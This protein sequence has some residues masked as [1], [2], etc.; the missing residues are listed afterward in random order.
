MITIQATEQCEK[1]KLYQGC[2]SPYMVSS[3]AENP[4]IMAVGEAPGA[5]EDAQGVPFVGKSG[6]LLREALK[7]ALGG[8]LEGVVRF[9]NVVRCRPPN[10]KITPQAINYCKHFAVEEIEHYKP[11][12]VFLFGNSPLKAILGETGITTWN[13][14]VVEREDAIYVP[15]YHPAYVLRN[16][17]AMDDW[18]TG[19]IN[20]IDAL[21]KEE[22][23]EDQ[24]DCEYP[25]S[26]W[27]LYEMRE[28]LQQ[29]EWIAYDTETTSL[30]PFA[31][32]AKII[33]ISLSDGKK[34]FA[35]PVDHDEDHWT[36]GDRKVLRHVLDMIFADHQGKII[37]HNLKFDLQF[38]LKQ[39]GFDFKSGGDSMLVSHLVDS[40]TGIHSLK[41]LAGL[42]L[43]MYDYDKPLKDYIQ[44]H[45]ETNPNRGGNYGKISLDVLLPYAAL[46][47]Y[48]TY[49]LYWLLY[50]ELTD[51]Q[52][53]FYH[54]VIMPVSDVLAYV[55]FNGFALDPF[56]IDRYTLI[57]QMRQEELYQELA[58]DPKVPALLKILQDRADTKMID[59]MYPYPLA[60][61]LG[62]PRKHFK[63]TKDRILYDDGKKMRNRKRPIVEFNPNSDHQLRI[64]YYKV[65]KIPFDANNLTKT[66]LAQTGENVLRPYKDDF[67]IIEVVRYYKLI[68]KVLSTYLLPARDTWAGVDGKARSDYLIHGS[69][70]GRLASREPNFQNIPS[71]DKEPGTLLDYLPIKNIFTSSFPDGVIMSVDEKGMELRVFASLADCPVMLEI[72]RSGKDFHTMIA[73]RISGVPYEDVT[74]PSRR[75][76]KSVN[77]AM[78]YAGNEYTLY[79]KFGIPIDD[80]RYAISTYKEELPSVE[81]YLEECV[82]FATE[83]GYI[84]TVFGRR[85]ALPYIK[86]MSDHNYQKRRGNMRNAINTPVQSAASDVLL[87]ALIILDAEMYKRKLRAMIVN[88]VHDSIVLDVPRNEIK[89]VAKLC[90]DVMENVV[91]YA[92][93]YMPSVDFSWLK[94]PLKVDI[95]IGTHYGTHVSYEEWENA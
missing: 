58:Q 94:A 61:D 34:T 90:K 27:A 75:M 16:S 59:E 35:F 12:L 79:H 52:K 83:H 74:V 48:A 95:D 19:M 62:T 78:L 57:Y 36:V 28:Y 38:T 24:I 87:C 31:E 81:D 21:M 77:F 64:L 49:K 30:K 66:G 68:S 54:E 46:D 39:F 55:Q 11:R 56:L 4:L 72:H 65:Y 20:G 22:E 93:T 88:T 67:P 50:L 45:P 53:D 8:D 13:G 60:N 69:V 7:G 9:T 18:L 26:A 84:E 25:A 37:G 43:G 32:D 15:L 1:C 70:T 6:K 80:G 10:N 23:E 41:R 76:Y 14:V 47:A 42:H 40:R 92:K 85:E 17:G 2:T 51:K 89:V 82:K 73:S 71:P 3:G 86:D 63:I 44:D 5:E 91:T 29:S 33:A